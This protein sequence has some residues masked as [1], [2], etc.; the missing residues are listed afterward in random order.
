MKNMKMYLYR[1]VTEK[2]KLLVEIIRSFL[3]VEYRIFNKQVRDYYFLPIS[4]QERTIK[5]LN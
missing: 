5:R 4:R 2:E 3:L 1:Q